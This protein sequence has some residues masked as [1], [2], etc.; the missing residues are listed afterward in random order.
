MRRWLL[1]LFIAALDVIGVGVAFFSA[2]FLRFDG[3]IP[4]AYLLRVV[5]YLPLFVVLMLFV[6]AAARLYTR[7]WRYAGVAEGIS[8][9]VAV[10]VD[11]GFWAGASVLLQGILPRSVYVIALCFFSFWRVV[12][13]LRCGCMRM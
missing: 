4:A 1:P 2:L 12:C 11:G 8:L 7:V 10:V 5:A 6:H 3:D 13:V 9:L